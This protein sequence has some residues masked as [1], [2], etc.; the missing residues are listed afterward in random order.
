MKE[1]DRDDASEIARRG[2]ELARS[3]FPLEAVD[4]L[5]RAARLGPADRDIHHALSEALQ[6]AG[7][8]L[9]CRGD[10]ETAIA[11]FQEAAA[12]EPADPRP[13]L[14]L[15]SALRGAGRVEDAIQAYRRALA[16]D[17]DHGDTLNALGAL[18]ASGGDLEEGIHHFEAAIRLRPDDASA[19]NN[20]GIACMM[21][22]RLEEARTWFDRSLSLRPDDAD[23]R[24]HRAQLALLCG[25][26]A[27]GWVDFE[28]RF[29]TRAGW[30]PLRTCP[31][32]RWRGEDLSGRS[33]FLHPEGGLGD[34]IQLV[35]YVP[36]LARRGATVIL[37]APLPLR[38]LLAS[39]EG[40]TELTTAGSPLPSTDFH[41]PLMSLP[42]GFGTK[43]GSIPGNVPYLTA[44]RP[45]PRPSNEE[46]RDNNHIRVGVAWAG[47]PRNLLD[48]QR[49]LSPAL[50]EPLSRV[51]N[52]QFHR[53]QLPTPGPGSE[54]APLTF[55]GGIDP[56][57]DLATTA[58][59][60][61]DLDLVL[62]VDTAIAHLAG[63][64]GRPVWN[65]LAFSPD[66]RWLLDRDDSPWYPTMRLFRQPRPGDW[67]AVIEAVVR[68]LAAIH[69]R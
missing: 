29:H 54:P 22:L 8:A 56:G 3:G 62:T 6:E 18:L 40:L 55:H 16:R 15:G 26:L 13:L 65:L 43:L 45:T 21:A 32:L 60:L 61:T 59:F 1:I 17:P 23:T 48:R 67:P 46:G 44:I 31:A 2:T 7:I 53:L 69:Y 41:S 28:A 30:N 24:H 36:L 20:L 14:G 63:A 34:T 49:S 57:A 33:I 38:R 5:R 37:E 25:D 64:L 47:N 11:L 50:L 10:L 52:V 42:R 35:R 51:P 68:E 12:R 39:L 66:W 58:T 19:M 9:A 27:A 4:L